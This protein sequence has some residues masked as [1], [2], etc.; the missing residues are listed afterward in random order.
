M[1]GVKNIGDAFETGKS[2]FGSLTNK[3]PDEGDDQFKSIKDAYANSDTALVEK[4]PKQVLGTRS[5][6]NPWRIIRYSKFGKSGQDYKFDLH[7]DEA[8]SDI[9]GPGTDK[10]T[11]LQGPENETAQKSSSDGETESKLSKLRPYVDEAKTAENPTA[12]EIINWAQNRGADSIPGGGSPVPYTAADFL[13]CKYYGKVPN[14]RL[15]TLRRYHI[16]VEDNIFIHASKSPLIPLAQAVTWYGTDIGNDL[17]KI[18]N[19]SWGL[20]WKP[21]NTAVTDVAGNEVKIEDIVSIF[22]PGIQGEQKQKLISVLSNTLLTGTS[23]IDLVKLAGWD[24]QLQEYIKGAYADNGPYWNRVL[25]PINVIDKTMIRDRGFADQPNITIVFEYSLRSYGGVN[26]KIAFLDLL[27]N[28][29]SLT[30]NTAPFWGGGIRYFEAT[31]PTIPGLAFEEHFAKGDL[32]GGISAA[33]EQM[34]GLASQNIE[35]LIKLADDIVS[36]KVKGDENISNIN[37]EMDTNRGATF[38]ASLPGKLISTKIGS[39]LKKPLMYRS[40]LDGRAVG[41]WHMTV[42]NPMNPMAMVGNLCLTNVNMTVGETL[43]IDDFPTEFKFT[44]TLQPG[45]PRAKQDIESIFNLGNGAIGYS[46]LPQP[47]SS[48]NSYGEANT[49]K[50][51]AYMNSDEKNMGTTTSFNGSKAGNDAQ[52]NN[53][54]FEQMNPEDQIKASVDKFGSRIAAMYGPAFSKTEILADYFKE[55]KTKD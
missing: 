43:G 7:L 40:F 12:A 6:F 9:R 29:L 46:Q 18:L 33:L 25:G 42:G 2:I 48:R 1:P 31:G 20:K 34:S 35:N 3:L 16:P 21:I 38:Q 14:N 15:V 36:G 19:L 41:E 55:F 13:W 27:S 28:F 8:L 54:T 30:Y 17:N 10:K 51:D 37:K 11:I 5:I 32:G 52:Q 49:I 23:Q 47:S 44:V 50:Q 39:L 22:R 24:S 4:Y 53:Q 26:P 45:R